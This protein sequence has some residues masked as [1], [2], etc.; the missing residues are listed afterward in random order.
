MN[1]NVLFDLTATQSNSESRFHGGSEYA[2]FVFFS[3]IKEGYTNFD[4]VYNKKYILDEQI[5]QVCKDRR[6]KLVGVDNIS[7]IEHLINK[8]LYNKFYSSLPYDFFN[9]K[10]DKTLFIMD[11]L[12][13]RPL[14]LQ[15]DIHDVYYAEGYIAKLKKLINLTLRKKTLDKKNKKK[16]QNLVEIENKL[17]CTISNHSKYSLLNFF[18]SLKPEEI[19]INYAPIDFSD[20][21]ENKDDYPKDDFYLL[22]SAN[23]RIKNNYRAIQAFD[24]LFSEGKLKGKKV[25]VLGLRNKEQFNIVNKNRFIIKDYVSEEVLV[26]FYKKAFCFV[27]P[28]L[29]EGFGYPPLQAMKY[30]TPVIC[31]AI[32]AVPEICQNSVLYFNPYSIFEIRNRILQITTDDSLYRELQDKGTNR[33]KELRIN[34]D[35][36]FRIFVEKVFS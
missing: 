7:E 29:N 35:K 31:S 22:V 18:P 20:F 34:Q 15:G 32:S 24:T 17:I 16:F 33:L 4:C 26:N 12:G 25:V 21:D 6:I 28:T 23:R 9:F 13:L 11:I 27:Y 8:N 19:S 30:K 5:R 2:K 10:I 36:M 1:K 14:E 3:G